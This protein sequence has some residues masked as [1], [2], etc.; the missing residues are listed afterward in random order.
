MFFFLVLFEKG[1]SY[2]YFALAIDFHFQFAL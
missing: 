1:G 2:P